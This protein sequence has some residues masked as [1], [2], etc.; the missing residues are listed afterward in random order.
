[1]IYLVCELI[2]AIQSFSYCVSRRIWHISQLLLWDSSSYVHLARHE[3]CNES[4]QSS[5]TRFVA[6][7]WRLFRFCLFVVVFFIVSFSS[8]LPPSLICSFQLVIEETPQTSVC[9]SLGVGSCRTA[10]CKQCCCLAAAADAPLGWLIDSRSGVKHGSVQGT[11]R[12]HKRDGAESDPNLIWN[13]KKSNYF[14]T[15]LYEMVG[16]SACACVHT[17]THFP[18]WASDPLHLQSCL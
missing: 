13:V 1:M 6:V 14:I 5:C 9:R 7:G 18:M 2:S 10:S 11:A 15:E 17:Y 3:A 12:R 4:L 16:D 8:I